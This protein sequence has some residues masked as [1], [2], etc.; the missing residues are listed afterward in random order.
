MI[1]AVAFQD[2][3]HAFPS[4]RASNGIALFNF[5]LRFDGLRLGARFYRG[6]RGDHQLDEFE[7]GS[8]VSN[9]HKALHVPG[10]VPA[11]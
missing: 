10:V 11:Q 1:G 4:V 3:A 5:L 2:C 8:L 9:F 7:M 6:L